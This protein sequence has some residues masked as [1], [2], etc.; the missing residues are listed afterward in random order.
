L[1]PLTIGNPQIALQTKVSRERFGIEVTKM[2]QKSPYR[3][4]QLITSLGLHSSIFV[5]PVDPLRGDV[6]QVCDILRTVVQHFEDDYILWY[7]AATCPFRD[8]V[9]HSKKD[10]PAASLVLGEGLKVS[11]YPCVTLL[12]SDGERHKGLCDQA[13]RCP[14]IYRHLGEQ[15]IRHWVDVEEL[16]CQTL[17]TVDSLVCGHVHP[18]HMVGHLGPWRSGSPGPISCIRGD[19]SRC[20]PR[21]RH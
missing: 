11:L 15:T 5:A 4:L 13:T 14:S 16:V 10:I 18:A 2:M 12:N 21:Y 17:E 8:V 6:M 9:I 20:R 3:A 19:G 7:T 1:L